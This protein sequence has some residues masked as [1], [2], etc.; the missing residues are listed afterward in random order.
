MISDVANQKT[1]RRQQGYDHAH[2]VT[3][4]RAASDKVPPRGNENGTHEIKRG[5]ESR[6]VG[7]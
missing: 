4:P 2:H 1:D 7:G 5:I 3:A 6:Q